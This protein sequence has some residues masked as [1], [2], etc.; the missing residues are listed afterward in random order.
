M[1]QR[2]YASTYG[3]FNTADPYQASGGPASPASWNRYSYT[4][5]DPVNRR[6]PRGLWDDI[7]S[8]DQSADGEFGTGGGGCG[9]LGTDAFGEGPPLIPQ[10]WC[11]PTMESPPDTIVPDPPCSITVA[12]LTAYMANTPAYGATGQPIGS[13]VTDRPLEAYAG[14]ILQDAVADNVDPRLLVAIAFVETKFGA[15]NCAG[16]PGTNNPF[17][18]G[19]L[20]PRPFKGGYSEA[21]SYAAGLLEGKIG[22]TTTVADLYN[23]NSG[24]QGYCNTA[25][26]DPT[27][28]NKRL[29]QQGGGVGLAGVYGPLQSPCYQ[30]QDGMFYQKTQ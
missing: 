24:R 7:P 11:T 22:P 13:S 5:G 14:V 1:D 18:I 21:I 17:C 8:L 10:D 27:Q 20:K 9:G 29:L 26:C 30:G 15:L 6:D 2:Y 3:R 28:V 23:P 16:V 25:E 12:S 4:R 19:G